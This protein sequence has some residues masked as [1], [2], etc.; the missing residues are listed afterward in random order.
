MAG[1]SMSDYTTFPLPARRGRLF[2]RRR[3]FLGLPL[4]RVGFQEAALHA[5][6]GDD[7]DAPLPPAHLVVALFPMPGEAEGAEDGDLVFDVPRLHLG[8][9]LRA[10]HRVRHGDGQTP[11]NPLAPS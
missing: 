9:A 6:V 4:G 2:L 1:T 5:A 8:A 7:G 3:R 10:L 11:L